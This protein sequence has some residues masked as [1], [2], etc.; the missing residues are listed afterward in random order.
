MRH[1]AKPGETNRQ[2]SARF[3]RQLALALTGGILLMA[4]T[5]LATWW[6]AGR[7]DDAARAASRRMV[8]GGIEALG[9]RAKATLLD[10]AIWTDAYDNI[11]AGDLEWMYGNIGQSVD[12]GTFDLVLVL[13]PG[14][15]P[16]GW[17]AGGGPVPVA[18]LLDPRR[19]RRSAGCSRTCLSTRARRGSPTP[20]PAARSGC[21]RSRG[22]CRRRACRRAPATPTCRG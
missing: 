1:D 20:A 14:R 16:L 22:W 8:A 4:A 13:P 21:W 12:I 3:S 5:V 7:Q 11:R 15:P 9:E 17:Q 2:V 18:D 6:M 19:S 10:Y